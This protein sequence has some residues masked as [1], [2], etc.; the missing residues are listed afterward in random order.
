[1]TT[2]TET[3]V[4]KLKI[5]RLTQTQFD[6][7]STIEPD[8]LYLVDPEFVGGKLLETDSNGDIVE[9]TVSKDSFVTDVQANGVSVVSSGV[10]NIPVAQMNG[11]GLL[12]LYTYD[13]GLSVVNNG[14]TVLGATTDQITGKTNTN[15]P[16]LPK[17]ID[18]ATK[19]G[20]TTNTIPLSDEE[21]TSANTWL[22][23]IQ[24]V[25]VNGTA[26]TKDANNTVDVSVPTSVKQI[27]TAGNGIRFDDRV[28]ID[29]TIVGSD[30]SITS[31]GIASGFSTSSYILTDSPIKKYA[32]D[33]T[34]V[35]SSFEIGTKVKIASGTG[36][37]GGYILAQQRNSTPPFASL[38]IYEGSGN[39]RIS[40]TLLGQSASNTEMT[41]SRDTD[42]WVK[43]TWNAE[44]KVEIYFSTDGITY[45]K[46]GESSS[47]IPAIPATVTAN[48]TNEF[49]T[50]INNL[51][52]I[53]FNLG[54]IDLKETY[55]KVN[56]TEIWRGAKMSTHID[57]DSQLPSQSGQSGKFLTTNGTTASWDNIPNELPNQ[58]EQD[59]KFLK[60]NGTNVS[61]EELKLADIAKAGTDIQFNDRVGVAGS[62]VGSDVS[63]TSAGIASGFSDSSYISVDSPIKKYT[64][65]ISSTITSF[66]MGAKAKIAS[67]TGAAGGVILA[68]QFKSG[69][70]TYGAF[71]LLRIGT[72]SISGAISSVGASASLTISRDTDYWIKVS[73]IAGNK[74][75]VYFSTDGITYTKEGESSIALQQISS[76]YINNLT[77]L[78]TA[79]NSI[80]T[81]TQ[82]NVF[83]KG[84]IDLKEAYVKVN[85]TEIW[86][87]AKLYTYI[88]ADAELP[89]QSGQSGK[90]L[91]T[92]GTSSSWA[93]L[94]QVDQTYNGTSTNAQ[95]G[96]AVKSAIDTAISSVYKPAGSVVFANLPT[97]G[98]TNLGNVYNMLDSFETDS[99]FVEGSGK[100]YPAGTNVVIVDTGSSTYKFDVLAGFIDLSGYQ[101]T[102]VS[103]TNIKTINNTSLLGSGDLDVLDIE[104]ATFG[105][106]TYSQIKS[107][108]DDG[109]TVKLKRNGY[110]SELTKCDDT[111][112]Y[113]S[114]ILCEKDNLNVD[115]YMLYTYHVIGN[116][117][118]WY[119][120]TSLQSKLPPQTGHNG[121]FLTTNGTTISWAT[122]D[123]LPSQ[124]GQSGKFLTTNGASASWTNIPT[125]IP[126]QSGN[127]GKFLTTDGSTVS[128]GTPTD[129]TYSAFVGADG[130]EAGTSGLVPAPVATD[131][132]KYLRGDGTWAEVSGG[133]S[134]L[135]DQAGHAGQFLTTNGTTASWGDAQT[136]SNLVTSISS[137]ST[138]TQYPS[139]K[140]MYDII[141]NIEAILA[142]V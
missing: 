88:D 125:E 102:L 103:G 108:Y 116:E 15:R 37:P 120:Y 41:I 137:S 67:G 115:S 117:W 35:F 25:K 135:P 134:S 77:S 2:K 7:A 105:T 36:A 47:S 52:S 50:G 63:I 32:T 96:I 126:S 3:P 33:V 1:M 44:N 5:N 64:T 89:S 129:T 16:I 59:G 122:V 30:V 93:S 54:S 9:S 19:V 58:S 26:L 118:N 79:G 49:T 112:A 11:T 140:C 70:E 90:F 71:A 20:L 66:E 136:T 132:T 113:F 124:S 65:D 28:G 82:M 104:W 69:E 38:S 29:G 97:P 40:A 6:N 138:D 31:A 101:P 12:K 45:T 23:S 8:E 123:A 76:N 72:S 133:G 80:V 13:Y 81:S 107:W 73:W 53:C 106:T 51:S 39:G 14:V 99:R 131:N 42:Y 94:P 92:D 74:V 61:W 75:E 55:V 109:K 24:S 86:R 121:Q 4:S 84:S 85:G 119:N 91:T 100:S 141:G 111:G 60:T 48:L 43:M 128:W 114:C 56:G 46:E 57:A 127:T 139:A 87:G 110:V 68:Q 62:I 98:S 18:L 10:A 34:G 142:T 83:N 130:S 78:F 21:K 17:N 95:S 27:A 22:G